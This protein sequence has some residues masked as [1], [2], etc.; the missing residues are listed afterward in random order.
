MHDIKL[1]RALLAEGYNHDDLRRLQQRSELVRVR[2]GAYVTV[3]RPDLAIDERHRRLVMATMPQLREGAILSHGSAAVLH[4]LPV[5]PEAVER[6]HVTRNRQGN[7]TRQ[8][9]PGA[10]HP[11]R[12]PRGHD[13]R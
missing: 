11:P 8:H 4:G 6:V 3:S 5:W 9:R 7:G 10:R 2:R 13:D 12:S 1:I